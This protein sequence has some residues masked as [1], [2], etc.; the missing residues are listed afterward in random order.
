[1]ESII[2]VNHLFKFYNH[3]TAV[4][5]LSF[6][7][8]KGDV[9]GFL[10][11]NGAGKSTTIRMLLTLIEPTSG[12]I[13]FWG[14][15]LQHNRIEIL[16]KVGAV[17]ERPDLYKYLSAYEN[18]NLFAK[19]S[20]L[21]LSK[22]QLLEQLDLVGLAD[23]WEGKIKTFSQ[24]MKQRLGI[25][26]ALVHNPEII[27]LDEPTNGLDPQGIV[28]IRNLILKLR[29]ERGKTILVSSHLLSEIE[30]IANRMLIIHQGK[31]VVEGNVSSL[32]DPSKMI[33]KIETADNHSAYSLLLKSK[34]S[35]QLK[36]SENE[37]HLNMEKKDIP[38]L[39]YF[40]SENKIDVFLIQPVHSLE[41]YFL[42]LT[43]KITT[44]SC[45]QYFILAPFYISFGHMRTYNIPPTIFSCGII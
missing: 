40:L 17:I 28:D 33:V 38:S 1:M 36:L 14:E 39:I 37:I 42:K 22:N 13:N 25:A 35:G 2:T 11:E 12:Q 18:L 10:G 16:K 15:N 7:V 19:M 23:R 45:S 34:W 31:K 20:G 24:G 26:V 41:D 6:S 44:L 5:D 4:N 21:K 9:F 3:F 32:L 27:I 30:I 43:N 29:N 8:Q